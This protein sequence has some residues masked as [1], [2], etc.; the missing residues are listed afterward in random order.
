MIKGGGFHAIGRRK[1]AVARVFLREG[2]GKFIVNGLETPAYF[3]RPNLDLHLREPLRVTGIGEK[4]DI[5]VNVVGGGKSGQAGAIRLGVARALL[6]VDQTLRPTLKTAGVLTRDPREV[7][8]KKY[9]L[10][11]AR[12]R[13]QYSKR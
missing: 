9:G 12:R 1:S 4:F 13:S 10:R 11:K 6:Q 7:E 2:D 3:G 8:R 5:M